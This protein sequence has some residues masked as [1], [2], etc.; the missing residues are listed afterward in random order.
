MT[1]YGCVAS[2]SKRLSTCREFINLS[3]FRRKNNI[4]IFP[5]NR[6]DAETKASRSAHRTSDCYLESYQT[7]ASNLHWVDLEL[8]LCG[9]LHASVYITNMDTSS[10]FE[11]RS[12]SLHRL[13][14]RVSTICGT[15][16]I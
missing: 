10:N 13:N 5:V 4:K 11:H 9:K 7:A 12:L 15:R 2:M 14:G 1:Y 3:S 16:N 6:F 8:T